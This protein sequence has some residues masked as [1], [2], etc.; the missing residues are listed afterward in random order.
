MNFRNKKVL[1]MGLGVLGGGVASTKWFLK[2]GAKVT[3]TD[4][5]DKKA[6]ASSIRAL[7]SAAKRIR[8]VLGEHREEDFGTN[9]II[10][11]NPAVPRESKYLAIA[12][13]HGRMIV[14]DARLFFDEVKSPVVAV[15]GTRGKTTTV[16]WLQFIL[17]SAGK[18]ALL[19]GNS[20]DV[21]LLSLAE[22]LK[23]KTT[24]VVELSS[25]QLEFL[26]EAKHAPD[27]AIITNLY[28][29][30][31]NRYGGMSDYARAKAGI[32]SGQ[33]KG[34]ALILNAENKW[35][36]F[37]LGQKPRSRT[38][39]FSTR[40]LPKGRRGVFIKNGALFFKSKEGTEEVIS[41]EAMDVLKE[42]GEHNLA[43]FAAT[44]L[45]AHLA[46]VPWFKIARAI[47][48]LPDVKY[49]EEIVLRNKNLTVVN[50]SAATSPD[51]TLA[52][53]R[54]FLKQG[55]VVLI[56]G[57]TDKNL[58]FK[59]L[60]RE[61]KKTLQP[62][63]VMFLN[64]SA[65]KKLIQ[66]LKKLHYF[67]NLGINLSEDLG[68]AIDCTTKVMRRKGGVNWVVLFSPGAASFEKFKN[69]FDRGEKFNLYSRQAFENRT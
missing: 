10:V 56:T 21:A 6:L 7:G 25:W 22:N 63:R 65:T 57:G 66:E 50:D 42:R 31:L 5:R 51:A 17:N 13:K 29:D 46:G 61:I 47:P 11:V 20:S 68:G 41:R 62:E 12:R 28:P 43:N 27:I 60:A 30:H 54:R 58:D 35:T 15:T 52:A 55:Q 38:Y 59:P 18:R 14:N 64:G 19:G 39:F 36:R 53:I 48:K 24:A 23:S 9:D 1:I 67:K 8:F 40:S 33:K 45:A 32:F 26:P 69:E 34:Q 2:R 16:N 44:A 3:V 37:F 49:R 4:M